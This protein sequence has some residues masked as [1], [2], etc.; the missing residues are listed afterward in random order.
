[1]HRVIQGIPRQSML[2]YPMPGEEGNPVPALAR[3]WRCTE[4]RGEVAMMRQLGPGFYDSM[5]AKIDQSVTRTRYDGLFHKLSPRSILEVGCGSGFLAKMI[6]QEYN[7]IYSGFDFSAEAIRNAN[8]RT[9]RPELFF[10]GDALD[11]RSYKSD[12]DTIVCMETLEHVDRDLEIIRLWR[13]T[14]WCVCSVPNFDYAGHVRSEVPCCKVGNCSLGGPL[15][16]L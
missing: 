15:I 11:S 8:Y 1:M 5:H 2:I 12:Y 16:G 13:D 10:V 7:G 14:T 4:Y 3:R 6:L 9:G